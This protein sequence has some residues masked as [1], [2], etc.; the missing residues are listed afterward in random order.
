MIRFTGKSLGF[1]LLSA[2][3]LIIVLVL[4]AY[5][6][7]AVF[8]EERKLRNELTNKGEL[9]AS[10]LAYSSRIGVFAENRDLLK[11]VATGIVAEHDV[12]LVGIYNADL[13]PLY[14]VNKT[15]TEKDIDHDDKK[16]DAVI[17]AGQDETLS[18]ETGNTQVF[19]KPVILKLFQNEEKTL[20]FDEKGADATARTI[21]YVKIALGKES[22]NREIL[23]IVARNAI[24]ALI[25]IGASVAVVYLRVRKI[26]KPLETLT[27]HVKVLGQGGIVMQ[28]PV[29]TMDEVGRLATAFNS[30][31]DERKAS[32]QAFQKILMD[33]HDGIGGITTNICMLSEVA[34]KASSPMDVNKALN[35]ILSL[36]REGMAEIRSLMYSLDRNDLNWHTLIVELRNQGTK[37]VGHHSMLFEIKAEV[38]EN[39]TRPGSLLCLHLFRIYREALTN[40]I[41]HSKA[42]NVMVGFHVNK[43][44]IILTIRDDGQGYDHASHSNKGRGVPNMKARAAEIGGAVM[45]TADAGTCVS[46]E[47]PLPIQSRPDGI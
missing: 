26:T 41:K 10:L 20:Y 5:T 36:S 17:K 27:R 30:M 1:R 47:I 43:E 8:R 37:T 39:D 32:Q 11:D 35:T 31:L 23:G 2:F 18:R 29:E 33:I 34:L 12:V 19:T 9:L 42:K 40:V 22:L 45:V 25:F 21:G 6:L 4:S 24:I 16:K 28:M 38:E 46:V 44:R 7:F 15:A 13:K 3:I 14:V